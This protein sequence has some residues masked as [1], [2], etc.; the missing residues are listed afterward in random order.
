MTESAPT[1]P[2]AWVWAALGLAGSVLVAYAAPHAVDDRVVGWWYEPGVPSGRGTSLVLV[3][4]GMAALCCAWLGLGRALPSRR[5]LLLIAAVWA[6]PLALAPPL[7]SRDVY[8]YLAQGTILRL[9]HSPYHTAPAA[10]AGLGH[11]H[12]LDAVSPFWRHTTAPYGPLFLGL[13]A[14][15][16]AV[17]GSHLVAGVLLTRA[18]ELIGAGL[19]AVYV[20]RLARSLGTDPRRAVW[21]ALLSPLVMLELIAAGHNDLL[22]VG[23]LAAGVAY[24]LDGR[25]LL[26]VAICALAATVKVPALAGAVFIAVAWGREELGRG[27]RARFIAGAGL[28]TLAILGAVTLVTGVSVDWLSTALFSTPA[29]VRLAITPATAVGYTL[30]S[31]LSDVGITVSHRGLE[32]A[33]GVAG[34]VLVALTGAILLY[35]VRVGRLVASLGGFLLIAA[36][37]GPAAWPWYFIWGL[38]LVCALRAAQDSLALALAIAVSAFAVKPNGILVLP[39]P[40]APAVVAVY[41]L[42]AAAVWWG[43]RRR[44]EALRPGAVRE[45]TPSALAGT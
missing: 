17:V 31:L 34:F 24:A 5:G 1:P 23:M 26:G 13:V 2:L 30:A 21:L 15:V 40:S 19:L 42:I 41:L 36:A 3:Y 16:T 28:I 6:L 11:Q 29:K 8:S 44:R 35:R 45:R 14:I 37:G 18:L 7:F 12:V 38:A 43:R 4:I 20:P 10:L 33:L 27:G 39:R 25:P 9:G 22:M 32:G